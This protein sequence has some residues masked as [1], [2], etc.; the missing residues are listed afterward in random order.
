MKEPFECAGLLHIPVMADAVV[1]YLIKPSTRLIV[2]CTFSTGGHSLE[3]LKAAPDSVFLIGIDLDEEALK[4]GSKRLSQY[5]DRILLRKGNFGQISTILSDYA[6]MVDAL[7]IDCGVSRL[8]ITEPQRGFSFDREGPL[9]MRFDRSSR[10]DAKG[11]LGKISLEELSDLLFKFGEKRARR[12]ACSIIE[13][14]EEGR[15]RTTA[16]LA[17]AVKSVAKVRAAKSLARVFLAIRASINAEVE[18]LTHALDSLCM[19]MNK[20][21]RVCV[22]TYHSIE[23][24]IV[25]SAFRKYTGRCICPP[26]S[27]SCTCGKVRA[28]KSITG[29]PIIPDKDEIERNPWA[30][31]AKMRVV[32]RCD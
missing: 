28:F 7:L 17:D 31:S 15:L 13:K 27:L 18:N 2:D 23:D 32:E 24:R 3:L 4:I 21:G 26:G 20:G 14:R 11:F 9:D 5:R 22:I 30:R 16:D 8:Q 1:R 25:K 29:K 19:L 10:I 6:A 12:I